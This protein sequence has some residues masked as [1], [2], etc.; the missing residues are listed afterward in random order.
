MKLIITVDTEE[1]TWGQYSPSGHTVRNI[2]RIPWLQD[3]FD[4]FHAKPSYLITYPVAKNE[5][6]VALLKGIMERGGCE[7]GMHCHP[8]NTPPFEEVS[9]EMNSM[10]CN[11]DGK[12]QFRKLKH[13]HS[14]IQKNFCIDPVSFRSGRWG[15]NQSVANNLYHL[16]Y[17]ID[18]SVTPYTDWTKF[19]G[20]SY[21]DLSPRPFRVPC[22][23]PTRGEGTGCLMEVPATIGYLQRNFAV[24]NYLFKVL[25]GRQ[26]RRLRLIG[27]LDRLNILNKVWLSPEKSDSRSMI[28]LAQRM[29]KNGY[30]LVNMFFHS[31]TL[32]AGLTDFVRNRK[33][34][35]HFVQCIREF[36]EFAR[37]EG[38]ESIRLSDSL[39]LLEGQGNGSCRPAVQ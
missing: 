34:E 10:L 9:N 16:G 33:E 1:D 17:R 39:Q 15:Y 35:K 24:S 32:K 31:P 25:S 7:I 20:P 5:K 38:I 28:R 37:A 22:E 3:V 18:T 29:M 8:W 21:R 23:G 2:E 12:L 11:L 13:L 14:T 19:Y 26:L 30:G 36:L 27:M 6:S 4:T